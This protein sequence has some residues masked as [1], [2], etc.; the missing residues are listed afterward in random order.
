MNFRN[1]LNHNHH[2]HLSHKS[3]LVLLLLLRT[4]LLCIKRRGTSKEDHHMLLPPNITTVLQMSPTATIT[5]LTTMIER[6]NRIM[7]VTRGML[8]TEHHRLLVSV[9][10]IITTGLATTT[11]PGLMIAEQGM[12]IRT[13]QT[14]LM[15]LDTVGMVRITATTIIT[16]REEAT[17]LCMVHPH[18]I[19]VTVTSTACLRLLELRTMT[20]TTPMGDTIV[21]I[22]NTTKGLTTRGTGNIIP[23]P[24]AAGV[25][26]LT[27]ASTPRIPC[28]TPTINLQLLT[29]MTLA[30]NSRPN[31]VTI[32]TPIRLLS[33]CSHRHPTTLMRN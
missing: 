6:G 32:A 7:A 10:P 31:L 4:L 20:H 21:L 9:K 12:I 29:S 8:G 5:I 24:P 23:H 11:I 14:T 27:V 2:H 25:I 28:T 17:L 18:P 13:I 22:H 15:T 3:Q 19:M 26:L 33:K 16:P 30:Y 1:E